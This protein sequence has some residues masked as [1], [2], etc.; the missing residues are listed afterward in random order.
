[1]TEPVEVLSMA[2][3]GTSLGLAGGIEVQLE[4]PIE[5]KEG[6]SVTVSVT[7]D[8]SSAVGYGPPGAG[9]YSGGSHC[10]THTAS[11]VEYCAHPIVVTPNATKN[12]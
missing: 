8:L 6:E 7:Y 1:M 2:E 9:T 12:E 5:I 4:E 11:N 3:E 10:Y